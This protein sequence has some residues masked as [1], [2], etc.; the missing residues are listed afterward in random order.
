MMFLLFSAELLPECG[1]KDISNRKKARVLSKQATM[2]LEQLSGKSDST[3]YF[4]HVS[5]I[6]KT[7]LLCDY[8]DS[9]PDR[10]GRVA[11]KFR[12]ANSKRILDLRPALLEGGMYHYSNR[13]NRQ[14]LEC[15]TLYMDVS[16]NSMFASQPDAEKGKVAYYAALLAYGEGN[17][18]DADRYAD[19]ALKDNFYAKD[20]AEIKVLC[21]KQTATTEADSARYLVALLELHDMAPR[22]QTYFKMLMEYFA[23]P[24]HENEMG[25]FA[26]D[27]IRK[28]ST[29]KLAWALKGESDMRVLRWNDAIAAYRKAATIDTTFVEAIFN[30]GICYC[31]L[32]QET[33]NANDARNGM[34]FL[35]KASALDPNCYSVDWREPL[36]KVKAAIE[37]HEKKTLMAATKNNNSVTKAS[38][39]RSKTKARRGSKVKRRKR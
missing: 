17:Y 19:E 22:N 11:P 32:A 15:F 36:A 33:K 29:N 9:K 25:L 35:E 5:D 1:A 13:S 37:E 7:S 8:Y 18:R 21:M 39:A 14:A 38:R 12:K 28:D 2:L 16:I 27:E 24:G 4:Q 10:K 6:I 34:L 3:A 20:A 30:M 26:I 23:S 31:L